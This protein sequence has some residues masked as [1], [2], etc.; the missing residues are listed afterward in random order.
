MAKTV[1]KLLGIVLVIVGV[2]GFVAPHLLGA[3]LMPLIIWS[4]W[5]QVQSL[6]TLALP[7]LWSCKRILLI[8]GIVYLLL[9][10]A[11][12]FMG[13]GPEHL[14]HVGR[15][16]DTRHGRSPHSRWAGCVFLAGGALGGRGRYA[17]RVLRNKSI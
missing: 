3:H 2:A 11:A 1:C 15:D 16:A 4:T 13:T 8:C 6:S 7:Q 14:F 12:G 5:F 17:R 9:G 10:C